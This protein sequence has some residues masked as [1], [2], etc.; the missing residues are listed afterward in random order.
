MKQVT[1][2]TAIS[3]AMTVA[4][5][6]QDLT[7]GEAVGM[8][9][10]NSPA[11]VAANE[12]S[13]AAESRARQATG[14]RL[15]SIDLSESFSYTDNPAEV[16][17]LKLNQNRFDFSD[18]MMSDPNNPDP[19]STFITSIEL[20]QPIYT[21]GKL[22]ARIGQAESMA[23]AEQLA[24]S[25]VL[26][27]VAFETI[28]AFV[29]LAKAR[30][31]VGLLTKARDTTAEHL[32]L[33]EAYARQGLIL[34]AEVLKATVFLAEMEE[35]LATATNGARL[36]EAALNFQL[37]AAQSIPRSLAA[38]PPPPAA[39]GSL[40]EWAAAALDRRRDLRAARSKLEAGRL[41]EKASRSG[42]LPEI[43]AM[44]KYEFYDDTIFGGNG[45]SGSIVAFARI[46]LYRGGSDRAAKA[47][48]RHETASF[49]ADI[50]RFEEGVLLEV[51][52]A[53]QDLATARI[54]QDTAAESLAA[55]REALRVREQRFKQGLDKMID[56]LDA[57]TAL[58]EAELRE[59]IARFDISLTSYR[60]LFASGSSLTRITEDS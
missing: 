15:P 2:L 58:R 12:R 22:S 10:E 37:G 1:A 25:H 27:Q 23:S 31:Q 38:M 32:E 20:T 13:L 57:E 43:G 36:A 45:R 51:E 59:L 18:F 41:E 53:L 49:E 56:L 54:R 60:L 16:F 34:D 40:E 42:Y 14:H 44:G 47:A 7:L 46:N 21:G 48:A 3:I 29:N 30:E 17:A 50:E 24:S 28:T 39:D 11:A 52:Q 5:S 4:A 6:A 55:A 33:A 26:E 35:L 9:L 8:A 19:L